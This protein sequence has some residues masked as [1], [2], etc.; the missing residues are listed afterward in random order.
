[1]QAKDIA[2]L[3]DDDWQVYVC[4]EAAVVNN[5]VTVQ[6]NTTWTGSQEFHAKL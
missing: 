3:G 6:P 4:A 1:M 2:D 5:P